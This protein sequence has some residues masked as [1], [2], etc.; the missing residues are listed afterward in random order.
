MRKV[1]D[2]GGSMGTTASVIQQPLQAPPRWRESPN[3]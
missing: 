1:S 2:A 3:T